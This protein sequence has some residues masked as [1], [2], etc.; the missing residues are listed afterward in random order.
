VP[1]IAAATC[2]RKKLGKCGAAL[3]LWWRIEAPLS[4]A[5]LGP[6]SPRGAGNAKL[7]SGIIR[8]G[9]GALCEPQ[10]IVYPVSGIRPGGEAKKKVADLITWGSDANLIAAVTVGLNRIRVHPAIWHGARMFHS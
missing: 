2:R 3:L 1:D 9:I 10:L 7:P 5:T 4:G 6:R 8:S